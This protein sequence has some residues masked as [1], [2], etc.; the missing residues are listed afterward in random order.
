MNNLI[1]TT[2]ENLN[3]NNKGY[4]RLGKL[5]LLTYLYKGLFFIYVYM[6]SVYFLLSEHI[7]EESQDSN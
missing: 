1:R 4:I 6:C 7:S 2:I 3:K 5:R